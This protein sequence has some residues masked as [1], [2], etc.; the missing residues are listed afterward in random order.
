[1]HPLL[2]TL[3]LGFILGIK[4]AF[5]TDHIIAVSTMVTE[6]K[7]AAK[8][9]LIGTFWGIGHTATLLAVGLIVLVLNVSIPDTVSA[10][11]ELIIAVILIV[12]GIQSLITKSHSFHAH[13]HHHGEQ[14]HAHIHTGH[15]HDRRR[16]SFLIGA[17]HGLA[18]SG[19]L[20]VLV[21]ATIQST[22]L[23]II[24]IL[25]FGIGSIISM[26]AISFLLGVPLTLS[27]K[28]FTAYERGIRIL[29][30]MASIVIGLYLA[31]TILTTNS[32]I[33]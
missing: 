7:N 28:Q 24:Y 15:H 27:V 30:G 11:F 6:Q 21:L 5:D 31:Y 20:M 14:T 10:Y 29:T 3:V 9:A 8:A 13:S 16:R 23:G 2:A 33:F 12:T 32:G 17:L 26:T 4:H 22:P 1:M 19:A 25:L 18:G